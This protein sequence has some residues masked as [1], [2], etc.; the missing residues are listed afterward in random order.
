MYQSY[1]YSNQSTFFQKLRSF[2]YIL[3]ISIL[4]VGAI[5]TFA[6]YS[7]DGGEILYHTKSHII[8]F[9]VF[10]IMM[11]LI[12]FINIKIWHSIGYFFYLIVLGL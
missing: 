11:I 4:L 12:S 2:D 10:F 1:S 9:S 7:T 6:M 8:R 5:S 3:I